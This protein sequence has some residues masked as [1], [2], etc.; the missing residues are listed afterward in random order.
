MINYLT[1][2]CKYLDINLFYKLCINIPIFKLIKKKK[3]IIFLDINK[4]NSNI[5]FKKI[6]KKIPNII[7]DIQILTNKLDYNFTNCKNVKITISELYKNNSNYNINTF[8]NYFGIEALDISCNNSNEFHFIKN[9]NFIHLTNLNNL[10][11]LFLKNIKH[12]NLVNCRKLSKIIH[13]NSILQLNLIDIHYNINIT[14]FLN[15]TSLAIINCSLLN[16]KILK[17]I[18]NLLIKLK[19]LTLNYSKNFN[20]ITCLNKI[21]NLELVGC[22]QI[23][24]G[25]DNLIYNEY[26]DLSYNKLN[27]FRQNHNKHIIL[28][29]MPIKSFDFKNLITLEIIGNQYITFE[30]TKHFKNIKYL[31]LSDTKIKN[32]HPIENLHELHLSFCLF[33]NEVP[34][35]KNL[36]ILNVSNSKNIVKLNT[37]N[38]DLLNITNCI[39]IKNI[40]NLKSKKIIK[41]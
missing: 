24:K 39:L 40:D 8:S 15:L 25:Y 20:D 2:I 33:L 17:E 28:N 41:Y 22:T 36:K 1:I 12:L 3:N 30:D 34:Y 11:V 5:N 35:I 27:I 10:K 29:F 7:F 18:S 19:T 32:I 21:K 31:N 26:L 13:N 16:N 37:P 38:L 4:S 14:S 9:I 6:L 23:K